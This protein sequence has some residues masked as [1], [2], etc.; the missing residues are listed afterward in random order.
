[1]RNWIITL[2]CLAY[3][4]SPIDLIPDLLIFFGWLDDLGVLAIL[5]QVL[6]SAAKKRRNLEDEDHQAAQ[7]KW[8][9]TANKPDER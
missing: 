7:A 2:L 4:V 8:A 3:I 6:R 5:I 9:N 1:M